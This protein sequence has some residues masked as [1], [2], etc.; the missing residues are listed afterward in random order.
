V[1]AAMREVRRVPRRAF[2]AG[3]GA[4]SLSLMLAASLRQSSA[5]A[6]SRPLFGAWVPGAPFDGSST[7]TTN[8]DAL[9]AALGARLQVLHWYRG[10]GDGAP[11]PIETL[12][13]VAARGAAPLLTW[14][15]WDYTRST[16]AQP[17]YA[18]GEIAGGRFDG[19][20]DSWAQALAALDQP[21]V[22]R[23]AHE[24][25]TQSYPWCVGI[26]GN[27]ADAYRA[28]WQRIVARF[29][30]AGA[31]NVWFL[32]CPSVDWAGSGRPPLGDLYPGDAWVDLVGLDGYNGGSELDWGGWQSFRSIFNGSLDTLTRISARDVW[33]AETASAEAGGSKADWITQM[34]ADLET[35]PRVRALIWFNERREADWR[36]E[37]SASSLSAMRAALGA[38]ATTPPATLTPTPTATPRTRGLRW[39]R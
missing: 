5:H 37:S 38:G 1:E 19:Y 15:P 8:I 20:I 26:L 11:P 35:R 7:A 25:N 24:M 28:A 30:G 34:W 9:E 36:I 18:L 29:R 4:G 12:R 21:V 3:L 33:I 16:L 13:L 32:W 23:P 27:T 2:V 10:W 14:E 39:N 22:L 31:T 6:A 17:E